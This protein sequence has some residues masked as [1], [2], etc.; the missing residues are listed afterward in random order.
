MA[1][2]LSTEEWIE[3]LHGGIR[4]LSLRILQAVYNSLD[5]TATAKA[6]AETIGENVR[7][8]N[9][10]IGNRFGKPIAKQ[11]NLRSD[12]YYGVPFQVFAPKRKDGL[13]DWIMREELI[14]ALEQTGLATAPEITKT[15]YLLTWNPTKWDWKELPERIQQIAS[16]VSIEDR[17]S[18]GTT[19]K[20]KSGDSFYL[21][22]LGLDPKGIL[23]S[24]VILSNVYKDTHWDGSGREAKYVKVRFDKL[25]AVDDQDFLSLTELNEPPFDAMNWTPQASGTQIPSAIAQILNV[26]FNGAEVKE[27]ILREEKADTLTDIRRLEAIYANAVPRVKEVISKVI[28]RGSVADVVKKYFKYECLACNAMGLHLGSFLKQDGEQYVEAHHVIHVSK[29]VKGSLSASNI[30]TLCATHHRQFH[31]GNVEATATTPEW[32]S[33]NIDDVEVKVPRIDAEKLLG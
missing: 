16:N 29:L 4:P 32:F 22:R 27:A 25:V 2:T 13:F 15:T 23:G 21:I 33:F 14:N 12:H 10:E 26:R 8:L 5:H 28:E 9:L 3:V 31:H 17:W 18:A 6:V 19:T 20:P 11:Y 30:I 1:K 7:T 24:G